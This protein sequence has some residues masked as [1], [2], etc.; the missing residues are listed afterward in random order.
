M[1]SITVLLGLLVL[2]LAGLLH[3][4]DVDDNED[5]ASQGQRVGRDPERNACFEEG[6]PPVGFEDVIGDEAVVDAGV[7]V[8]FQPGELFCADVDHLDGSVT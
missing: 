4:R 7:A 2:Y 5:K 6:S 8:L 1:I 3:G